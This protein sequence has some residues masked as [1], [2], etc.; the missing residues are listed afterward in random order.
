M[1]MTADLYIRVSTDEQADKGYSQRN[2]EEML[3]KYCNANAIQVRHVIFEDHSAKTFN[4]PEWKALVLNLRKHKGGAD[5]VLFTKWDRF[6]RNAGDAYQMINVLRKLGADPQ[7]IE[8]PL[9][10]SIPENKMMLAFYLAAPEVENDRRAL[11]VFFGMRRAKKEGRY[12][13][14]A[15]LGY[16]NKADEQG[17]KYIAPKEPQATILK[18]AFVELASGIGNTEQI[19]KLAKGKGLTSTKSLFWFALRNPVYCGKIFIP[20]HKDEES[21]F[22][23]AQHEPIIPESLFYE[24]QDVLDGRGRRYKVKAVANESL[25]LRGFLVCPKCSKLL[26]GSASKGRYK[27]YPYYHCVGECTCR[28]RAEN[29]NNL[30]VQELK[31][32]IPRPELKDL[33]RISLTKAFYSQ[34]SQSQ[35]SRKELV[36]QIKEQ[37]N[38]LARAQELLLSEQI[39]PTD[40][41]TMKEVCA[42]KLNK[43]QVKLASLSTYTGSIDILLKDGLDT[44]FQL[45]RIY[46]KGSID[47]KRQVIGSIYPE[48]LSFDGEHLRTTRINE[49]VRIIY[50]MGKDLPG[51]EKGQS[52]IIS[53]L[54]SHVGKTGFEPAT[55]WSQTRCAT[56]LR[57]FPILPDQPLPVNNSGPS[58]GRKSSHLQL[59]L[60]IK[61]QICRVPII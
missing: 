25:P 34:S 20:R 31:K 16:Q 14:L 38:R 33:Y 26:S 52:G 42:E 24:V 30:F 58:L 37:E 28:F 21:R 45:D 19:Y 51:N 9:D 8:Q 22:V 44:L 27:Y 15:P 46:E 10:L 61:L 4:R 23:K 60:Q 49:A 40:Y 17:R 56:G 1:N 6:S 57:Y 3:R 55:P 36:E 50:A 13:G 35:G 41:R 48:K 59:T 53:A 5:L 7:A 32:Y 12:M 18:W 2:Q 54:S 11:N 43:L 39:E 29:I 47:V